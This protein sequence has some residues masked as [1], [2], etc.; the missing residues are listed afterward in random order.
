MRHVIYLLELN[1]KLKKMYN[2]GNYS[3]L[4]VTLL[5]WIA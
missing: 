3:K 5:S 4:L 2:E 1:L